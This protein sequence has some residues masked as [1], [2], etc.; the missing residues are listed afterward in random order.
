M[1]AIGQFELL[2]IITTVRLFDL[3]DVVTI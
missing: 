3:K 1:S 2:L